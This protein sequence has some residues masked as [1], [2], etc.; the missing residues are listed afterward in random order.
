M[1]QLIGKIESLIN[2]K[3]VEADTE[4]GNR[5]AVVG[6]HAESESDREKQAGEM[7]KMKHGAHAVACGGERAFEAKPYDHDH[8]EGPEHMASHGFKKPRMLGHELGQKRKK[9]G[10]GTWRHSRVSR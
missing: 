8:G 7:I 3:M 9:I 10:H 2:K 1:V 4:T 5:M 6:D